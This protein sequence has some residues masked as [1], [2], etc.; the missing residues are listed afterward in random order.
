MLCLFSSGLDGS[1]RRHEKGDSE[2]R[3]YAFWSSP[4]TKT[5]RFFK[6][7]LI[8]KLIKV[9]KKQNEHPQTQGEQYQQI[10]SF[11]DKAET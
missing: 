10:D 8:N 9:E 7:A 6:K 5:K 11:S 1:A 2:E 4:E 3:K